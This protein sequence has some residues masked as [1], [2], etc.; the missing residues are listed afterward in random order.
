MGAASHKMYKLPAIQTPCRGSDTS[1][2]QDFSPLIT[3]RFLGGM[4]FL[5][6]PDVKG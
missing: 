2:P 5:F 1:I 3:R 4:Y 6:I